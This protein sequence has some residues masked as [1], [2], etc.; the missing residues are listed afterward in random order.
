MYL[1]FIIFCKLILDYL[2]FLNDDTYFFKIMFY[3]IC[4]HQLVALHCCMVD[5]HENAMQ[6]RNRRTRFEEYYIALFRSTFKYID[7]L[8]SIVAYRCYMIWS[9]LSLFFIWFDF[10]QSRYINSTIIKYDEKI[11]FGWNISS[12]FKTCMQTILFKL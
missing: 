11:Y 5:F 8:L 6:F 3:F 10:N 7:I 1:I 4:L 2:I 12:D 9:T